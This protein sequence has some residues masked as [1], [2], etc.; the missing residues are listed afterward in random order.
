[1]TGTEFF[2]LGSLIVKKIFFLRFSIVFFIRHV[3]ADS[4]C[5]LLMMGMWIKPVVPCH[6]V[7][8]GTYLHSFVK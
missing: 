5:P 3:L 2:I 8:A 1:M 6:V 7:R 4:V